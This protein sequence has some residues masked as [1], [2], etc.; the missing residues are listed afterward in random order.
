[1]TYENANKQIITDVDKLSLN[2]YKQ[3][4]DDYSEASNS[5]I[6]EMATLWAN[7]KNVK[8]EDMYNFAIQYNRL[9]KM[10]DEIEKEYIKYSKLAGEKVA[11]NSFLTINESFYRHQYMLDFF[12][13]SDKVQLTFSAINPYIVEASIY[14]TIESWQKIQ[15]EAIAKIYGNPQSYFPQNGTL[16]ELLVKNRVEEVAKI[17]QTISSAII[18]GESYKD[19]SNLVKDIIGEGAIKNG[20]VVASGAKFKALRIARTEGGR[21][22]NAGSYANTQV[23]KS[24]GLEV[25]RQWLATLDGRTRDTHQ[26]LDGK[27]ED[28]NGLFHADGESADYPQHFGVASLDI[29]CRCTVIDRIEGVELESRRGKDKDGKSKVFEWINYPEWAEKNGLKKN[30]N[31]AYYYEKNSKK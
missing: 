3:I 28:E 11:D 26:T 12:T 20:E 9:D 30:S 17:R 4:L 19:T 15:S 10:L 13:G 7:A 24:Q 2:I 8:P 22:Y 1:M 14:G 23:A 27:F 6:K 5:I 18:R 31:G 21:N 16:T 29:N 25:K